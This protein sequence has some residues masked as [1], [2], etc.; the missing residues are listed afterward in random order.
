MGRLTQGLI[1]IFEK[2][3]LMCQEGNCNPK[4][5]HLQMAKVFSEQGQ[6]D[7]AHFHMKKVLEADPKFNIDSRRKQNPFKDPAVTEREMEALRKAGAPEHPPS[8]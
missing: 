5:T 3:L 1:A 7:Q 2:I 6:Y 8:E 4:W